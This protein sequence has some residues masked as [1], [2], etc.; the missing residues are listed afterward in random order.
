M[1]IGIQGD[2]GSNNHRVAKLFSENHSWG[3][4]EIVPLR[5]TLGV[6]TSL[7]AREVDLGTFAWEL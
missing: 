6:L 1:K 2:I 7:D 4:V 5:P 3:D